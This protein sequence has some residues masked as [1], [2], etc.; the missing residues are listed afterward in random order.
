MPESRVSDWPSGGNSEWD[1]SDPCLPLSAICGFRDEPE[2]FQIEDALRVP[3]ATAHARFAFESGIDFP[4]AQ[5]LKKYIRI[6]TLQESWDRCE[7]GDQGPE[8][9]EGW[10][11]PEGAATYYWSD[12]N[13]PEAHPVWYSRRTPSVWRP[14]GNTFLNNNTLVYNPATNIMTYNFQPAGTGP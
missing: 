8:P 12:A 14:Y 7:D 2:H 5:T 13:D 9:S 11:P 10:T 3:R 4:A 6:Y 1:P